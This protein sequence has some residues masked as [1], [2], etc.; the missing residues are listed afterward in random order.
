MNI[1]YKLIFY[2][3]VIFLVVFDVIYLIVWVLSIQMTPLKAL[4]AA[5]FAAFCTPWAR[6][7]NGEQG[8]KVVIRNYAFIVYNKVLRKS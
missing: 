6:R 3:I 7:T 1:R 4:V 5:I 8:G 2:N